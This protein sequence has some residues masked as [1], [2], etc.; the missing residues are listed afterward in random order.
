MSGFHSTLLRWLMLRFD[1]RLFLRDNEGFRSDP[2]G[3]GGRPG[4]TGGDWKPSVAGEKREPG[5]G[6]AVDLAQQVV[7]VRLVVGW[8]EADVVYARSDSGSIMLFVPTKTCRLIDDVTTFTFAFRTQPGSRSPSYASL[9]YPVLLRPIP[10]H[11]TSHWP[12]KST[13]NQITPVASH[14]PGVRVLS[15]VFGARK[16]IYGPPMTR[17]SKSSW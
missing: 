1:G 6:I 5:M 14:R 4:V 11:Y 17:S 3:C 13:P 2:A 12:T 8:G 16:D 15:D 9:R 7:R 10:V